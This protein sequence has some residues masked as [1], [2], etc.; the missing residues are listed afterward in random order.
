MRFAYRAVSASGRRT[1]GK[2]DAGNLTDLEM[3]LKRMG[4]DLIS[5]K[6]VQRGKLSFG[7]RRMP[8]RDLINFCFHLEQLTKA[9]VP[10]LDGLADL[11]DTIKPPL[12]R[13]AIASLIEDIEGGQTLSQAMAAHPALFSR[14]FVSLVRAGE[15]SGQLPEILANL[16]ESLKWE[17]E[18][19]SQT[20]KLLLYPSFVAAIVIAAMAFLMIYL[21]PQLKSF[22]KGMG[23]TLPLHTQVLFF[24]SDLLAGYWYIFVLLTVGS[25][26]VV[27]FILYRSPQARLQLDRLKLRQPVLGQI[28][29]K[30]ILARF[31][32]IL[33]MLYAA[34]IPVLESINITRHV[35]D[36]RVVYQALQQVEQA[37]REGSSVAGAFHDTALFPS[38][39][40]RML[41][42][43][44]STGNLDTALLNVSYFYNRDVREAVARAQ[45]MIEPVLT[46]CMGIMLGWIMLSV[47]GPIYDVISRIKP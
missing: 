8:R 28:L 1:R 9:G 46:V 25:L 7:K 14:V 24:L 11:R 29:N 43:G 13:E 20:K 18:L 31:A 32:N 15:A 19:A 35:V 42:V 33:A 37:I 47:I 41:R 26:L 21:V 2:L 22:V 27:L 34:G 30:I 40:T 12:F 10:I 16:A 3:R 36:N 23:Q 5:S 4:L 39:V 6:P 38:L 44:E 17:D 45:T